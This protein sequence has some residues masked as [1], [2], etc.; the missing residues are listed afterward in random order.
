MRVRSQRTKRLII[1]SIPGLAILL[2]LIIGALF[3]ALAGINPLKAYA[4]MVRGTFGN[5]Y[6]FGEMLTRFVPLLFCGLAFSLAMKV[7]FFNV[8]AEGQLYMGALAALIVG[9]YVKGLPAPLHLP[10]TLAAGFA[11]GAV[12]CYIAGALKLIVGADEIINT[13]MLTYVAIL[14]TDFL[15]KGPLR[16]PTGTLDQSSVIAVSARLAHIL[17]GTRLHS[18]I[19]LALAAAF[20]IYY[21][22]WKTPLGFQIRAIGAN[23]HAAA[24]AGINIA[25]GTTM[26]VI[27]SG[28]LAGLGGAAELAGNQYRMLHGFSLGYGFDAIGAAVMGKHHPAGIV[29]ASLLFAFI[30][31]GAGAMQRG[32]GVPFPILSVLQGIII[33][34]IVASNF[35]TNRLT[36]DHIGGRV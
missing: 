13:I 5:L 24:Y 33:I 27:I 32:I 26:A 31:V 11:A 28:G 36:S 8:G 30:R 10:L 12:W 7:G 1:S 14:L 19:F 22:I 16:D 29:L 4:F 34:T 18:G 20:V 25:T 21:L 35:V 3:I 6:G 9:V 15:V 2:A 17:P 23:R